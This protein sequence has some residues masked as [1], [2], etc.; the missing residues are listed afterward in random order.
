MRLYLL[1][2]IKNGMYALSDEGYIYKLDTDVY[3]H[4]WYCETD[5]FLGSTIDIKYIKKIQVLADIYTGGELKNIL[6]I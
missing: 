2:I 1:H 5:L 4:N 3:S 6:S